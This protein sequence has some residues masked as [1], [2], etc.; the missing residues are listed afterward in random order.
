M[1]DTTT[2]HGRQR[3][4]VERADRDAQVPIQADRLRM[5]LEVAERSILALRDAW[6][7]NR[8]DQPPS[9]ALLNKLANGLQAS[10][11]ASIRDGIAREL[12]PAEHGAREAKRLA[13]W[14]S[15]DGDPQDGPVIILGSRIENSLRARGVVEFGYFW[16]VLHLISPAAM[17]VAALGIV[18]GV[19]S[20][21][22]ALRSYVALWRLFAALVELE[23]LSLRPN[24]F[25]QAWALGVCARLNIPGAE[26]PS[27]LTVDEADA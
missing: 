23:G 7:T 8:P 18:G 24:P 17:R 13:R 22:T 15:G 6:R 1:N 4:G 21:D 20:D 27:T 25:D 14:L 12:L 26:I 9:Y 19:Q 2:T 16:L 5:G 3:G 11:R 10:T